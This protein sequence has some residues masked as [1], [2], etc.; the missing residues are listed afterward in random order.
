M[1]WFLYHKDLRHERVKTLFSHH[2]V[3]VCFYRAELPFFFFLSRF[4][5]TN[6]MIH[7]TTGEGGGY[8]FIY[9]LPLP[10]HRHLDIGQ[11]IVAET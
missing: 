8:L 1:E 11:V 7:R 2:I 5:F 10:L 3:K 4:S 6:F 9:F